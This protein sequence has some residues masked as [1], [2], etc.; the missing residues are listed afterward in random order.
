MTESSAAKKL[1]EALTKYMRDAG[2]LRDGELVIEWMMTVVS[3]LP[4][5]MDAHKY[6]KLYSGGSMP[7][8]H[9]LGLLEYHKADVLNDMMNEG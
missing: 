4:D 8:H 2:L 1:E 5:Q 9:I 3:V 6:T 7:N